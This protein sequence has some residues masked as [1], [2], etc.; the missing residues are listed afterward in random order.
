MT[1]K[2]GIPRALLYHQFSVLWH[3]FF[4]WLDVEVIVSGE[5]NK[6]TVDLGSA[7]VVDEVCLPVKIFFG[8]VAQLPLKELDYLFIP[9]LV[10]IE[11]K[12]YICP[13]IM[14]LPDMLEASGLAMPPLIKPVLNLTAQNNYEDFLKETARFLGKDFFKIKKAWQKGLQEQKKY[15][16]A[17]L[18][19]TN[20][21]EIDTGNIDTGK[22]NVLLLGHQ[23]VTDDRYINLNLQEKLRRLGYNILLPRHIPHEIQEALV[24]KLPKSMFWTHGRALLGSAF[25]FSGLPGFKGVIILSSFGCGIDSFIVNMVVRYLNKV[26]IPSLNITLDEHT[27]EAGIDTR[28]EAFFDLL[29]SRRE[30]DEDYFSAYGQFLGNSEG[31]FGVSG[32]H[33][34]YAA[35][36]K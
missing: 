11:K 27:G 6:L 1:I 19:R 31:A 3:N 34:Y 8:H 2:V 29:C 26:K 25:Y 5:T 10:S 32:A 9:R 15:E 33:R 21:Y 14:G 24:K 30:N 13:K 7:R 36:Y 16:L 28:V 12:A 20:S 23:Y 4:N 18:K 17:Q 35:P 22:L